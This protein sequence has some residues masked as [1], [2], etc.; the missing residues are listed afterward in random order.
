MN[1][2]RRMASQERVSW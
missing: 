1:F 2:G